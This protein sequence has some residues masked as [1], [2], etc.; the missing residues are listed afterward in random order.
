MTQK[1]LFQ[2][3]DKYQVKVDEDRLAALNLAD[4][5]SGNFSDAAT[6]IYTNRQNVSEKEFM[7]VIGRL[8][9]FPTDFDACS[10]L[11]KR[12]LQS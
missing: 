10:H 6:V 9:S 7:A 12:R 3:R 11:I 8:M 4:Y 5:A 1:L 2:L